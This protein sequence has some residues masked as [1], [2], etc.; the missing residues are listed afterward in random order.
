MY[1]HEKEGG[2]PRNMSQMH[3]FHDALMDNG[4]SDLGAEG[5]SFTWINKRKE[6]YHIKERLDRFVANTEW[7]NTF[8]SFEVKNLNFYGSDHRPIQ[9]TT[10]QADRSTIQSVQRRFMF[11]HKWL[12]EDNFDSQIRSQ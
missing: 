10:K 7:I 12:M 8:S 1:D 3:N 9:I 6:P 11:E 5:P 2:V 4:L